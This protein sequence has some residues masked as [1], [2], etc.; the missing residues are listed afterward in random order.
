MASRSSLLF[1]S[2]PLVAVSLRALATFRSC[3]ITCCRLK[4]VSN[5]NH[6]S[7]DVVSS[8]AKSVKGVLRAR[9]AVESSLR[10]RPRRCILRS[11]LGLDRQ[12]QRGHGVS[13]ASA[14]E[15]LVGYAQRDMPPNMLRVAA[16]PE[17][18]SEREGVPLRAFS[19]SM[20]GAECPC[21]TGENMV[22]HP[23]ELAITFCPPWRR[24]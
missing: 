13:E 15:L 17:S 21:A 1:A 10:G 2:P 11:S 19:C 3:R 12:I 4:A 7:R 16:D 9:L 14:T 8:A 6:Q 23:W 22:K 20:A 18:A 24:E 5:P